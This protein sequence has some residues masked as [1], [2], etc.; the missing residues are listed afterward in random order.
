MQR[1]QVRKSEQISPDVTLTI[2][3]D[4]PITKKEDVL[5]T[6]TSF[7]GAGCELYRYKPRKLL[8]KYEHDDLTEYFL[9][10]AVTYLSFPHPIFKKRFQ[11]KSWYKDFYNDHKNDP[12]TKIRLIGLY[13]Y[14]GLFVFVDFNIEDYIENNINSSAAHVFSNDIFQAVKYGVFK[15]TDSRGNHI[16]SVVGDKF[17]NYLNDTLEAGDVFSLYKLFND[18]FAF[19]EWLK[20]DIS[21]EEMKQKNWYQWKGTEWPGWLLESKFADFIRE[22]HCENK[23]EYIG[24]IKSADKLDFDLLFKEDNFYG[25]IKSSDIKNKSMPGNDKVNVIQAI[26]RHE[27]LWIVLFE[28][29]T[30]KDT[31]RNNEMAIARM[32][33]KGE[34]YRPGGKISYKTRMKHSVKYTRMRV[35]ELNQINMNTVLSDF[36][37]GRQ[38]SGAKRKAKFMIKKR[39]IDNYI[40]FSYDW[41]GN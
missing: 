20:A 16:T 15:K 28:H 1:V 35:F 17:L 8:Y 34:A 25:D 23:L 36:N 24:H 19:G 22:K 5:A 9:L 4:Q 27:K 33:L 21:I 7:L 12:N 37:Q 13:H 11:L 2:D 14:D 6:L 32:R 3:Y 41:Q 30:I 18:S 26:Q 31:E 10:G 38:Q 29:E 39:E 40:I